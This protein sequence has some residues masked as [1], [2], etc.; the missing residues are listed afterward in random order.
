[1]IDK[2]PDVA[3]EA[4]KFFLHF[5]EGSGVLHR[6][7]DLQPVADDAPVL[8][9]GGDF[10]FIIAGDLLRIEVVEGMPGSSPFYAGS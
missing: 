4:A 1:M 10:S 7:F 2:S 6:R 9:Q 5:E 3:V 8:E